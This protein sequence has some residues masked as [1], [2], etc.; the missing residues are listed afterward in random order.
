M[1]SRSKLGKQKPMK[2]VLGVVVICIVVGLLVYAVQSGLLDSFFSKKTETSSNEYT[3]PSI[4]VFTTASNVTGLDNYTQQTYFERGDTVY[5]YQ[6]YTNLFHNVSGC[7][8][9]NFT[10]NITVYDSDANICYS[11][12]VD[13]YYIDYVEKGCKW[14][15]KTNESWLEGWYG[16]TSHLIDHIS[17][18]NASRAALFCL[19]CVQ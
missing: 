2:L 18:K 6:E 15:F 19:D 5:V 14:S 9:C 3:P 8:M 11:K 13:V 17:N 12:S 1:S 7:G 4:T 10:V 16:I